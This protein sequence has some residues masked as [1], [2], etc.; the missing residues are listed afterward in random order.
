MSSQLPIQ[1]QAGVS[2]LR[3]ASGVLNRSSIAFFS[4]WPVM[5]PETTLDPISLRPG[6]F[7]TADELLCPPPLFLALM[8]WG[9]DTHGHSLP[10]CGDKCEDGKPEQEKE[11][12]N[13]GT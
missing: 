3:A 6:S 10:L 4:N 1:H 5:G 12:Q 11:Q 9:C 13:G 2:F 8:G 7:N